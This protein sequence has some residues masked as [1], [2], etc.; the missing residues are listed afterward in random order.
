MRIRSFTAT[1]MPEAI[2]RVR[3]ELGPDAVILSSEKSRRGIT[4]RAAAESLL[5]SPDSPST[6]NEILAGIADDVS[7]SLEERLLAALSLGGSLSATPAPAMEP[8]HLR[9]QRISACLAFHE[10]APELGQRL[11]R[12]AA[13]FIDADA[14]TS[15]AQALDGVIACEPLPVSHDRPV[16]LVGLPGAGKTAC[17][18]RLAIRAV[19]AGKAVELVT[20]DVTRA[21]AQSQITAY[22]ELI[23]TKVHVAATVEDLAAHCTKPGATKP[24]ERLVRVI[25]TVGINPFLRSD[26]EH[27]RALIAASGAEPILVASPAG[28]DFEDHAAIFR[29]LGVRRVIVSRVDTARRLG[30]I[31][32][33]VARVGLVLS[34][35]SSSPF[36]GEAM[37]PLNPFTLA[38]LILDM[39]PKSTDVLETAA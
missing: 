28:G 37:V 1:T 34:H 23:R 29:G 13:R 12:D 30:G 32:N 35:A 38:R 8:P 25:D 7:R 33:A 14:V 39:H 16:I 6:G 26:I 19:L 4:L 10:V 9:E 17:A 24:G 22:A 21:G 20:T 2:A 18:A 11:V 36:I 27:L 15:L 3:L 5:P 31:I